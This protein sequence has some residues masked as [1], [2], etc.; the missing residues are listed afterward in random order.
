MVFDDGSGD[1][2]QDRALLQHTEGPATLQLFARCCLCA[3]SDG[4]ARLQ[5]LLNDCTASPA[6]QAVVNTHCPVEAALLSCLT[7]PPLVAHGALL[8]ALVH[9][10]QSWGSTN[11]LAATRRG[12]LLQQLHVLAEAQEA[13]DALR[14]AALDLKL[15]DTWLGRHPIVG[16]PQSLMLLLHV[17]LQ[18]LQRLARAG[19]AGSA[20]GQWLLPSSVRVQLQSMQLLQ[21][22]RGAGGTPSSSSSSLHALLLTLLDAGRGYLAPAAYVLRDI[23]HQRAGN[24]HVQLAVHTASLRLHAAH[25]ACLRSAGDA[26]GAARHAHVLATECASLPTL[27]GGVDPAQGGA[28]VGCEGAHAALAVGMA[29]LQLL[30]AADDASQSANHLQAACCALSSAA[31]AVPQGVDHG[32]DREWAAVHCAA[33]LQ[34]AR[35]CLRVLGRDGSGGKG[36]V[37]SIP[38]GAEHVAASSILSAMQYADGVLVFLLGGGCTR[39]LHWILP[40][41]CCCEGGG[42]CRGGCRG[43]CRRRQVN[44][45]QANAC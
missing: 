9:V 37:D 10:G 22:G 42:C 6:S 30:G 1:A 17:R 34:L 5:R 27:L 16:P 20:H 23:K 19:L 26:V 2:S 11:P 43:G 25:A 45:T 32:V 18:L 40:C 41:C 14:H 21:R 4:Q 24:S 38:G 7:D 35:L 13:L 12:A 33:S 8:G 44:R 28:V 3:G 15:L 29:Q 36:G 39:A 31:A